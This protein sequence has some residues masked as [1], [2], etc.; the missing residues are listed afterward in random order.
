MHKSN[1]SLGETPGVAITATNDHGLFDPVATSTSGV[2]LSDISKFLDAS[3]QRKL[4][5]QQSLVSL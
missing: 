2:P 5:Y 1:A 4:S 3:F